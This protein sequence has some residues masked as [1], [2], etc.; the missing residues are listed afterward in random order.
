MREP[1][2]IHGY[3]LAVHYA[4]SDT[5]SLGGSYTYFEGENSDTDDPLTGRYISPAKFIA[6]L[7][8]QPTDAT[9]LA[10]SYQ[11]IGD[12]DKFDP[13]DDSYSIYEGPVDGYQLLNV[14]GSYTLRNWDIYASVENLLNEDYFPVR[15]QSNSPGQ[16]LRQGPGAHSHCWGYLPFLTAMRLAPNRRRSHTHCL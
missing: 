8:W 4:A 15:A 14:S 1:Q 6:Y 9:R 16:L 12:R 3:E 10:L 7:D 13:V 2:E 11:H 5:L